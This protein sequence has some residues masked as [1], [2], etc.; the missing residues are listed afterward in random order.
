MGANCTDS[1]VFFDKGRLKVFS[2][3][4]GIE[5]IATG[6][7]LAVGMG[8]TF[9]CSGSRDATSN[10]ERRPWATTAS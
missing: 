8:I 9:W 4:L 3:E 6:G 2:E 10:L 1:K 5:R 7:I